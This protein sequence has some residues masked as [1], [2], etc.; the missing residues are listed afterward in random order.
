[1]DEITNKLLAGDIII[2]SQNKFSFST[3][4]FIRFGNFSKYGFSRRGW[5]HAALYV[6]DGEVVEAFPTG[7]VKRSLKDAYLN[8]DYRI[9]VLRR[10]GG[11]SQSLGQA[12]EFCKSKVGKTY[13]Q[14]ALIYYVIVQILPPI[15]QFLLNT[16]AV[17]QWLNNK[18]AFYCS[19]LVAQS[20][21]EA[22]T[23]CF[24][25]APDRIMPV[26]LYSNE[27][28][29]E[30]ILEL[31]AP[32]QNFIKKAAIC[33]GYTIAILIWLVLS[34]IIVFVAVQLVIR[35]LAAT[36]NQQKDASSDEAKK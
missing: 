19:E 33:L 35:A 12:V 5:T 10:K 6:G 7:I 29:F 24:D 34:A 4:L 3:S 23:Y 11:A 17:D 18:D 1:M 8:G 16:K 30:R 26:D 25:R 9:S 22:N 20:L 32:K 13:D 14:K 28:C 2:T 36:K 21:L 31:P 27:Y 15:L